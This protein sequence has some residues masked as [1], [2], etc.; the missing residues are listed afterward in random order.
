MNTALTFRRF[1]ALDIVLVEPNV[2][3][4]EIAKKLGFE[5]IDPSSEDVTKRI[6]QR[7][8]GLGA[9]F[10]VDCAGQQSVISS[11]HNAVKINGKIVI[12]AGYP[13]PPMF[14]F[15]Q[16]MFRELTIQ[17]V[18]NSTRKDFEIASDLLM[19]VPEYDILSKDIYMIDQAPEMFD[20]VSKSN[21]FM[22]IIFQM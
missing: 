18:R 14:S 22:K 21:E 4:R 6:L 20:R 10:V 5:A 19:N 8:G 3:K 1:G 9:D 12:L 2:K 7:S 16:G 15:H 17:F 13:T 11:L